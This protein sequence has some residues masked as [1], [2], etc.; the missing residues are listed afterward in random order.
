MGKGIFHKDAFLQ[1]LTRLL[2]SQK[3]NADCLHLFNKEGK[4][5]Q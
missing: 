2:Q 5:L 4:Y 3:S 1:D